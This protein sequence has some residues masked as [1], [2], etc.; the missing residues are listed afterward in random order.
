METLYEFLRNSAMDAKNYFDASDAPIPPFKQNQFGFSFGGPVEIPKMYHGRDKTFFF[1]DY[2]GTRV[3]SSQTVITTVPPEA[4]RTG[5]FS[6]F[7]TIY[8]PATT[9]INP[10][11][12]LPANRFPAIRFLHRASIQWRSNL[13]IFSRHP[14]FPAAFRAPAWRTTILQTRPQSA[15]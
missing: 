8:D 14:I 3:R 9:V 6:G 5:D 2:Q 15:T 13:L 7:Q 12:R 11:E 4:W 10:D 1:A